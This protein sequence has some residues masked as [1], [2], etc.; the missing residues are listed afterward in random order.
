GGSSGMAGRRVVPSDSFDRGGFSTLTDVGAGG[1]GSGARPLGKLRA[2]ARPANPS[3]STGSRRSQ[4][5]AETG[6]RCDG[7]GTG[8][9]TTGRVMG[10]Q[11]SAS[12][13]SG[14]GGAAGLGGSRSTGGD[15]GRER[16]ATPA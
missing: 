15:A 13:G 16:P 6:R 7:R 11:S 4:T 3:S 14:S 10:S 8:G 9:A 2:T 12:A 5:L 1:R